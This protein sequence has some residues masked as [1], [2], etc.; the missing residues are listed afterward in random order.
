MDIE[1]RSDAIDTAQCVAGMSDKKEADAIKIPVRSDDP[2]KDGKDVKD[3]KV[4]AS[5]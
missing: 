4:L 2:K 5:T 1:A 3:D